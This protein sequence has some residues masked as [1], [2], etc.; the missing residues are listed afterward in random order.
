MRID[1]PLGA[2]Q[3]TDYLVGLGHRASLMENPQH[4]YTQLLLSAVPNP[5]AG[6]RTQ[7]VQARGE[8]ASLI[9]P[10]P[11]CPFAPRCAHAM[12]ACRQSMP[13]RADDRAGSLAAL[14]PLRVEL[15]NATG[16]A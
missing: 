4:P 9:D 11:G 7:E 1:N 14:P 6:L 12:D 10:P 15:M 13:A 8:I 5:R 16:A 2:K 3:A